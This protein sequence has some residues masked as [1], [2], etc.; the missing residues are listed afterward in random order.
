MLQH[1]DIDPNVGCDSE[2]PSTTACD[3][4]HIEV[5]RLML[6]SPKVD[7][8]CEHVG[9]EVKGNSLTLLGYKWCCPL[10]CSTLERK[11]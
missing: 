2:N 1:P 7:V 8:N 3:K 4:G 11:R 5:V 9:L 10:H 6:Q